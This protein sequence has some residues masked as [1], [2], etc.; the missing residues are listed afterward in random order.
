MAETG[1]PARGGALVPRS[2][3]NVARYE[4]NMMRL[5]AL[6]SAAWIVTG[7]A[8]VV[9]W[10]H[11][12]GASLGLSTLGIWVIAGAGVL[13]FRELA[14]V[15]YRWLR[16]IQRR[17]WLGGSEVALAPEELEH[18]PPPL[19]AL[20]LEARRLRT[21]IQSHARDADEL[22]D[23]LAAW[24]VHAGALEPSHAERLR[25]LD[26]GPLRSLGRLVREQGELLD[27]WNERAYRRLQAA[28]PVLMHAERQIT[29]LRDDVYR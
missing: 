3:A 25:G 24:L 4:R 18:L 11:A 29:S 22:V 23:G 16:D 1:D 14:L 2:R 17:R 6:T 27:L 7:I 28:V 13:G 12:L 9:P 20:V 21:E 15:V 19:A 5:G 26:L 10:A 8:F